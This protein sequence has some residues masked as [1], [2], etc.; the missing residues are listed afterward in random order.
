MQTL[1]HQVWAWDLRFCTSDKLSGDTD[2]AGP[3]LMEEQGT[4]RPR[5]LHWHKEEVCYHW[6]RGRELS[7]TQAT[8]RYKAEVECHEEEQEHGQSCSPKACPRLELDQ[9]NWEPPNIATALHWAMSKSHSQ[10][11]EEHQHGERS[12]QWK[13]EDGVWTVRKTLWHTRPHTKHEVTSV[14]HWK[15]LQSAWLKRTIA[16]RRPTPPKLPTNY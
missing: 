5:I 8:Y 1:I 10:L 14:H 11:G 12:P 9:K 7:P 15:T 6:G 16:T 2:A 3:A 4:L 13:A